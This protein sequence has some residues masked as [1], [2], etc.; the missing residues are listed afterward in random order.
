MGEA[1]ILHGLRLRDGEAR[2]VRAELLEPL[3]DD[4]WRAVVT[5]AGRV[6]PGDRLRFGEPSESSV[7]LLSFL[8][9]EVV[10]LAGDAA[11]LAFAFSGPALTEALD[12]LGYRPPD[13]SGSGTLA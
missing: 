3:G 1:M 2:P 12:R 7:C 11:V 9:A 8:D 13:R 5:P 6:R 10:A 4:R